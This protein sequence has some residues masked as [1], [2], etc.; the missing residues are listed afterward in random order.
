MVSIKVY[1][2]AKENNLSSIEVIKVCGTIGIEVKSHM[3]SIDAGQIKKVL[4]SIKKKDLSIKFPRNGF[5]LF[6]IVL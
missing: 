4:D 3:S 2:L 1:E 6:I 5:T